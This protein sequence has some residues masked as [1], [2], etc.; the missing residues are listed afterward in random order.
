[1]ENHEHLCQSRSRKK[2]SR[3][4]VSS[5]WASGSVGYLVPSHKDICDGTGAVRYGADALL[6]MASLGP[7][8]SMRKVAV[9]RHLLHVNLIGI[10]SVFERVQHRVLNGIREHRPDQETRK[11]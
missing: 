11:P 6:I 3:V 9:F 7:E 5:K 2:P 1:M 8:R 10:H 4:H